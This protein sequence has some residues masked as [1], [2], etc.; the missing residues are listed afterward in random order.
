MKLDFND[1]KFFLEL[2]FVKIKYKNMG[3]L[4]NSFKRKTYCDIVFKLGINT[5]FDPWKS[6]NY[7]TTKEPKNHVLLKK[8]NLIFLQL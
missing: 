8:L 7:F 3:G 4:L 5:H 2:E 1:I 6:K